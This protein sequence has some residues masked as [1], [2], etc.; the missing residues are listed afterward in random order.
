[1][2]KGL[3]SE[4]RQPLCCHLEIPRFGDPGNA[5]V[6]QPFCFFPSLGGLRQQGL[7]F[8][9]HLGGSHSDSS[10]LWEPKTTVDL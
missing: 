4:N 9:P 10:S 2:S 6:M 5:G 3:I 1:M 7:C 8:F